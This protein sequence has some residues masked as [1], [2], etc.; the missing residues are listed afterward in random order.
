MTAVRIRLGEGDGPVTSAS[1]GVRAIRTPRHEEPMTLTPR[2][3]T[4]PIV[5]VLDPDERSRVDAAG[6]G[7]YRAIH[8]ESVADAIEDL[9]RRRVSA[10]LL[11]VVRCG[12]EF[13]RRTAT[14]VREFPS[15]PTVALLG[16]EPAS[17][18]S[19]LQ[20]GNAGVTRLVDV[21]VPA[22]WSR[23]RQ[24]L[25]SEALLE[26]DRIALDAIRRE[27]GDMSADCYAFFDALF[28]ASER[29]RTIRE[30]ALRLGV[31]PSTLM[32]RFFRARL[33]APK[34]YLAYARLLRAARLFEDAGHSIADV[35]NA[36]D[37]SSPQSFGRHIVTFLG[38]SAGEFRRT[39]TAER[40][41]ERFLAELVVPHTESLRKL[42]ALMLRPG[43]RSVPPSV[44]DRRPAMHRR[45]S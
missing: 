3:L 43:M 19:L 4:A 45:A 9:K 34:R 2:A 8:R 26:T 30:L 12:R 11:S 18:E 28:V 1:Q 5:T 44:R 20:L 17:A 31:L 23:L 25:G 24:I 29:L 10:V 27:L 42:R 13:D 16:G 37:F 7:L 32:S 38:I 6:A 33:P 39:H 41:L 36:L 14:V 35:S 21:R 22:G 15:V 40:M